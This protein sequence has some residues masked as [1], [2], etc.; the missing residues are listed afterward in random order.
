MLAACLKSFFTPPMIIPKR[1][2]REEPFYPVAPPHGKNRTRPAR[3][4]IP[5][6]APLTYK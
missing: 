5:T 2:K 1:S 6:T 4:Y 3:Q